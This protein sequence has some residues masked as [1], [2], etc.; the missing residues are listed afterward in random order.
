MA[1]ILSSRPENVKSFLS[2]Y[3]SRS[4]TRRKSFET[5]AKDKFGLITRFTFR[6]HFQAE[7]ACVLQGLFD[8]KVVHDQ[9]NAVYILPQ[10]SRLP[11]EKK[12]TNVQ[13]HQAD[14]GFGLGDF[15]V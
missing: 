10:F 1:V 11:T 15:G 4:P 6:V 7:D 5:L 14:F 12:L 2:I 13:T 9:V 8:E 3:K